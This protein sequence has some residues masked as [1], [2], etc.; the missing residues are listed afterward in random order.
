MVNMENA[1]ANKKTLRQLAGCFF[2]NIP[3]K[4]GMCNFCIQSD[5]CPVSD[6][7]KNAFFSLN[8][9]YEKYLLKM[10]KEKENK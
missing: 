7:D 5:I 9:N 10:K 4:S 2:G 6:D 1:K 8:G 3:V